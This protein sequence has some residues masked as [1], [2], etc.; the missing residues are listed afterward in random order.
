MTD[1]ETRIEIAISDYHASGFAAQNIDEETITS[2]M[3]GAAGAQPAEISQV[4]EKLMY[5]LEHY[6]TADTRGMPPIETLG[7]TIRRLVLQA[8]SGV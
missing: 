5:V 3:A 8:G 6:A 4:T 2:F 1:M 7:E